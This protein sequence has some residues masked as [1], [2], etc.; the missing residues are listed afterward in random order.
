MNT[1][2]EAISKIKKEN[3]SKYHYTLSLLQ[4]GQ[5]KGL[6]DKKSITRIQQ[7]I[8]LLLKELILKYTNGKSTSVK[9]ETAENIQNSILY[10]IDI[11][12]ASYS[13]PEES[14][15]IITKDN[16][17]KKIY[18]EGVEILERTF[19]ETENLYRYVKSNKLNVPLEVYNTSID[20]ALLMF[21]ANYDI[22]YNAHNT[23]TFLDYPLVFD[24]MK[25]QGVLYIKNYLET[26]KMETL[27][28]KYYSIKD[29][30]NLL[31]N[32]GH[33]YNVD[34]KQTPINIFEIVL[35]NSIFSAILSDNITNLNISI[36]QYEILHEILTQSTPD[37]TKAVINEAVNKIIEKL[38]IKDN[39]LINYIQQYKPFLLARLLNSIEND[40]LQNIIIT[41]IRETKKEKI[42]FSSKKSMCDS[43]FRTLVEKI[44]NSSK[45]AD[46]ITLIATKVKSLDDLIDILSAD[47]LY[48]NEFKDLY[49]N[50]SDIELAVLAKI[51]F[52]EEL[53]VGQLDLFNI[54]ANES[55]EEEWKQRY[56]E[57]IIE[58]G[59]N[60]KRKIEQLISQIEF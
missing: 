52:F 49:K 12:L 16:N 17:L 14:L 19:K 60:R 20:V 15:S 56:I 48:G 6:I 21:F 59:E 2:I 25:V 10:T 33:V 53:R 54:E 5:K 50:I 26:F 7:Q 46:K 44:K 43:I 9:V 4:E 36:T 18:K 27:F 32:Y 45:T 42:I 34:Y 11:K 40:C 31:E 41:D 47:C 30:K 37:E 24:N 29:I 55:Y 28:C 57:Y 35:T 22:N 13:N 51:V 8:I 58:L 1:K 23:M 3:I 39:N 38:M